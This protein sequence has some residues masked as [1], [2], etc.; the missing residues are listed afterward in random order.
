MDEEEHQNQNLV[1]A[2]LKQGL[3]E[4]EGRWLSCM[5]NADNSKL[6]GILNDVCGT[7]RQ[8]QP[9]VWSSMR[10]EQKLVLEPLC[11]RDAMV[12]L[13]RQIRKIEANDADD[14]GV[15]NAIRN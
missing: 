5:D 7:S 3:N 8:G 15:M 6:S 12:A 1:V 11:A 14:D 9:H 2:T 10:S 4:T 13:W